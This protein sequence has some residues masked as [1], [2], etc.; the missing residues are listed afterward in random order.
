MAVLLSL[1]IPAAWRTGVTDQ[2]R[3]S[4]IPQYTLEL[5]EERSGTD[6]AAASPEHIGQRR[7]QEEGG[8]NPRDEE[9]KEHGGISLRSPIFSDEADD[10]RIGLR[11]LNQN[12]NTGKITIATWL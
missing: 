7:G 1:P 11:R 12:C 6:I 5:R 3:T 9:I 8:Q 4:S 10:S 2:I